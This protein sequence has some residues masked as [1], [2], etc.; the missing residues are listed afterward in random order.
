MQLTVVQLFVGLMVAVIASQEPQERD[1]MRWLRE[2]GIKF[3]GLELANFAKHGR[4]VRTRRFVRQHETFLHVPANATISPIIARDHFRRIAPPG[5]DLAAKPC[6]LSIL[7]VMREA[8]R[9]TTHGG[10]REPPLPPSEWSPYIRMLPAHLPIPVFYA[11][12]Q[13]G[14]LALQILLDTPTSG[15]RIKNRLDRINAQLNDLADAEIVLFP[16]VS[17]HKCMEKQNERLKQVS[18]EERNPVLAIEI[19]V[20][21]GTTAGVV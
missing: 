10:R 5:T 2:R 12:T 4:G 16:L 17:S 15:Q 8:L 13:H 6:E 21:E 19:C 9:V 3:N 14:S 18:R 20:D 1:F 11:G 7:F